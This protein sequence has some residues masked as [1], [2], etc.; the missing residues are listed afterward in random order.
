MTRKLGKAWLSL[1]A[2][3]AEGSRS[4]GTSDERREVVDGR[5]KEK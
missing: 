5:R 1:T 2:N 3:E 4:K